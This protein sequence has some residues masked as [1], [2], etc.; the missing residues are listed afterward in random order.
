MMP[1]HSAEPSAD[2]RSLEAYARA[3]VEHLKARNYAA[4]SV[5]YKHAALTW[6]IAWCRERGIRRIEAVTRPVLQRY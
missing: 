2:A 1:A 4:Q 3:Y 5:V 6:F